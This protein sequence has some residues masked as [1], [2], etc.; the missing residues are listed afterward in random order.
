MLVYR[1]A[2]ARYADNLIASGR[3]ARWNPNEVNMIYTASSRSLA[4]LENAVHRSQSGL[5]H[6]FKIM[7]IGIPD[8]I[9]I[10]TI[11]L[12]DLPADWTDYNQMYTTQRI[13]ENWIKENRTVILQVPSSIIE[14]E[15]NYLLNPDH[16]DFELIRIVKT[17]PFVFDKRIKKSK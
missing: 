3:A 6:L 15:V 11:S 2:L 5:S 16:K 13:G 9:K 4:C 14:E 12:N 10:K 17:L 7:S 8:Q 1:I